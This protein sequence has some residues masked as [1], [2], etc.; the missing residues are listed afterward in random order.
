MCEL[1]HF[2]PQLSQTPW[3]LSHYMKQTYLT[4]CRRFLQFVIKGSCF[5]L[6]YFLDADC[7]QALAPQH[8]SL[9]Q[10][11]QTKSM[12]PDV[13]TPLKVETSPTYSCLAPLTQKWS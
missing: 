4:C 12:T 5:L 8:A 13:W 1:Y 3:T 6:C 2:E 10:P 9:Q 11:H 7:L